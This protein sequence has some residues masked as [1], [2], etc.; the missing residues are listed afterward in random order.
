MSVRY[1]QGSRSKHRMYYDDV[2]NRRPA[3][4]AAQARA[5]QQSAFARAAAAS[6]RPGAFGVGPVPV[7]PSAATQRALARKAAAAMASVIVRDLSLV[8]GAV[9]NPLTEN[10]YRRV[11]AKTFPSGFPGWDAINAKYTSDANLNRTNEDP[12]DD[13]QPG[14]YTANGFDVGPYALPSTVGLIDYDDG[15]I[16]GRRYWGYFP[17]LSSAPHTQSPKPQAEDW[18]TVESVEAIQAGAMPATTNRTDVLGQPRTRVADLSRALV[19]L[20]IGA[21]TQTAIQIDIPPR[22]PTRIKVRRKPPNRRPGPRVR[23]RKV[24]FG[25]ALGLAWGALSSITEALDLIN[26]LSLASSYH[27]DSMLLEGFIPGSMAQKIYHL[28]GPPQGIKSVDLDL[29]ADILIDET[30]EDLA[31]GIVGS[32]IGQQNRRYNRPV[33]IQTGPVL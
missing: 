29:L 4:T 24:R 9:F 14:E 32:A 26:A 18:P 15:D 6:G 16:F 27:P 12:S 30:L 20:G 7:I 28:F 22:G 1:A 13:L 2:F 21:L 33:G 8:A 5:A 3:P 19:A 17:G 11:V 25:R 23:E 31:F 10:V